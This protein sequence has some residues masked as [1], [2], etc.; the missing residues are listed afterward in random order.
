MATAQEY[1]DAFAEA[2]NVT[3]AIAY[4]LE[5]QKV[6]GMQSFMWCRPSDAYRT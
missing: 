2:G 3:T 5:A 4:A 6:T 1:I